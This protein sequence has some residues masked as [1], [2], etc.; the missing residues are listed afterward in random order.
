MIHR[1]RRSTARAA[2]RRSRGL[3]AAG[4]FVLLGCPAPAGAYTASAVSSAATVSYW[5]AGDPRTTREITHRLIVH[6]GQAAEQLTVQVEHGGGLILDGPGTLT[7]ATVISSVSFKAPDPGRRDV[8]VPPHN[9]SSASS[10]RLTLAS[11]STTT[12]R[13]TQTLELQAAPRDAGVFSAFWRISVDGDRAVPPVRLRDTAPRLIGIRPSTLGLTAVTTT[14][15]DATS[16][17]V[18]SGAAITIRG[19]LFPG[20]RGDH[21]VVWAYG[22]GDTA[23]APLATVNVNRHGRFALLSWRPRLP[24]PYEL[25]ARY[26]GRPGA[27]EATRSPCPGPLVQVTVRP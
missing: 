11:Q 14:G 6:S 24:G 25:F 20:R 12:L 16:F 8:C 5:G 17:A 26:A 7:L 13:Y 22:P 18:P 21:V 3:A 9:G 19:T 27:L 2:L 1:R 10:Y 23:P 4:M 15:R